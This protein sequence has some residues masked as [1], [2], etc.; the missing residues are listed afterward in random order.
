M[1]RDLRALKNEYL[2]EKEIAKGAPRLPSAFATDWLFTDNRGDFPFG[3]HRLSSLYRNSMD[4]ASALIKRYFSASFSLK[5]SNS[6]HQRAT[7]P[8]VAT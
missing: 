8:G 5:Y 7:T 4:A 6:T 1:T 2:D 3:G